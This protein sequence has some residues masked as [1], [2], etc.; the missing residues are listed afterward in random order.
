MDKG[1]LG[2][3][4][5]QSVNDLAELSHDAEIGAIKELTSQVDSAVS[6]QKLVLNVAHTTGA[7][8]LRHIVASPPVRPYL[9]Q[10]LYWLVLMA[11]D[12]QQSDLI[13]KG[14]PDNLEPDEC[15]Q[16]LGLAVK[17]GHVGI[18]QSLVSKGARPSD[19]LM[20][21]LVESYNE[22][23]TTIDN[24]ILTTLGPHY[25]WR[26]LAGL[27]DHHDC[28]NL[29]ERALERS[30]P[31]LLVLACANMSLDQQCDLM[32]WDLTQEQVLLIFAHM[33]IERGALLSANDAMRSGYLG[34]KF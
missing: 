14:L 5:K 31:A 29:V 3:T 18:V 1:D 17:K 10:T 19:G 28:L 8:L 13:D 16:G 15:D 11:I 7:E 34:G 26:K 2:M 12:H 21:S 25:N 4:S 23:S 22:N 32:E 33:H 9:K 6:A 24:K 20:R 27:C 30:N